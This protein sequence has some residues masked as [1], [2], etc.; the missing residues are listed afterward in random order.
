MKA[1]NRAYELGIFRTHHPGVPV[2]SIGNITAGGTGKTPFAVWLCTL[3]ENCGA[4]VAILSRGYGADRDTGIDDENRML[5]NVAPGVPVIVD[6]DRVNGAAE[7]VERH[8][9][10]V[11][12]LDDGFQH[13]RLHRDCDIVLIDALWPFGGGYLLPRGLLREPAESL[14]RANGV[15]ITRA[16]LVDATRLEELKT[17]IKDLA[18][19]VL[20]AT[21][22]HAPDEIEPV[23]VSEKRAHPEPLRPRSE[24][25]EYWGAFC[26]L[27]NP[28]GFRG[29]LVGMGVDLAFFE[30]FPDHHPYSPEE[31]AELLRQVQRTGAKGLLTTQ[32]DAMKVSN[33]LADLPDSGMSPD[34]KPL[35]YALKVRMEVMG[36]RKE[37][38]Q[39]VRKVMGGSA[40]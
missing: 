22:K 28:D 2:I 36:G 1:R 26:G 37:L 12:V 31:I 38:E 27:G 19:G 40:R 18:E 13:R 23:G 5:S 15:V 25:G 32:K 30:A 8:G 9:V 20:V 39:M 7:A 33:L 14:A 4:T 10:D 11:V 17:K 35:I 34:G 24:R 6:P 16:D 29:T 21:A 3:L